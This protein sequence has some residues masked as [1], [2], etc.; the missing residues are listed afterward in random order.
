MRT[1]A[2]GAS[3]LAVLA[4]HEEKLEGLGSVFGFPYTPEYDLACFKKLRAP[5]LQSALSAIEKRL[6]KNPAAGDLAL[7]GRLRRIFGDVQGAARDFSAALERDPS[8][9]E[10]HAW[11]GEINLRS[12]QALP[13]LDAAIRLRR[14]RPW[15][16]LYRA[17]FWLAA[18]EPGRALP[19]LRRVMAREP[20]SGLG[21]LL[22]GRAYADLGRRRAAYRCFSSA[23]LVK[24]TCAAAHLLATQNAPSKRLARRHM[25]NAYNADPAIGFV[26]R[27]IRREQRDDAP[28]D[29][30]KTLRFCFEHPELI[31]AY[32]GHELTVDR[33]DEFPLDQYRQAL[34]FLRANPESAWAGA[35]VAHTLCYVLGRAE[36]AVGY[37]DRAVAQ[38]P[39]SGWIRAWRASAS[40]MNG[41]PERAFK[42]INACIRLQPEYH[43]AYVW[44]GAMYR[45]RGKIREALADLNRAIPHDPF[46]R[47][48]WQER[49]LCRRAIG[50]FVGA[51]QDLDHAFRIDHRYHWA[52]RSGR[53]A[54][55]EE[56]SAAAAELDRAVEGNPSSASL[57]MWRGRLMMQRKEMSRALRDFEAAV[58][59]DPRYALGQ[60]WYGRA[61]S[62]AGQP[63]RGV[64]LL[65]RGVQLDP[66]LWIGYG[67][68]AE[69][70]FSQG[71][72]GEA[73]R[74]LSTLLKRKPQAPWPL[75]LRAKLRMALGRV[76]A[77]IRDLEGALQRD[78]KYPEGYLL[79]ARAELRRGGLARAHRALTRCLDIAPNM[80]EA[81]LVRA[82]LNAARGR[83]QAVLE[84][85]AILLRDH[86]YML[87]EGQL[88]EIR[89]LL[90]ASPAGR[91]L[92]ASDK[93]RISS[94]GG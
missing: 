51:A 61:L 52:I 40:L 76:Q 15:P 78:G 18:G 25:L 24:P 37:L 41:R 62:E 77:A 83:H 89:A 56:L 44:R 57:R 16:Y 22:M 19:D 70:L 32:G 94:R 26:M 2:A 28:I 85:Y 60:A 86:P 81:Y 12:P 66:Q 69:A 93:R 31:E 43:V 35:L 91:S 14:A 29:L 75:Y 27:L 90:S 67:W 21:L 38:A 6:T 39:D 63:E 9:A 50:D 49:S 33:Y 82:Q 3:L 34:S 48:A 23:T 92:G 20:D 30:P 65:R 58:N 13:S 47:F 8:C 5:E 80:P 73:M 1:D 84:D 59:L 10:A 64:P 87:N 4:A 74:T 17:A 72:S 88:G 53:E 42:D 36:E 68:L 54:T 71:H 79:L 46:Y 55:E 11:M 45:R 7:R